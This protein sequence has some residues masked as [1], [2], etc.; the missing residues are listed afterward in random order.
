[1]IMFALRGEHTRDLLTLDGRPIVH[2]SREEMEWLLPG[3]H[4]VR[5]TGRDLRTRS[6]LP[7]LPLRQHPD[8]SHLTWPLDRAQFRT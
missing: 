7:P 1:M 5:V 4:V 3:S 6:P 2:D 8:L